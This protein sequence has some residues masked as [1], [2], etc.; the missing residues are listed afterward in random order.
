[1]ERIKWFLEARFGLFIHWGLYSILG[2]GEWVMFHEHIPVEEYRKLMEKF[3]AENYD[4][5]EWARIAK[6]AGMK[7]AVMTSRHHDG[8]SLFDTSVSDFNSLNTPAGRDL[9][10]EYVEAFRSEGL[11]VGIYYSL[12]DWRWPAYWKGPRKDPEGWSKFLNYV[13]TQVEEL[14]SNYGRIDILWYDGG[15]PY[16]AEDWKSRELNER[17]RE[18]QPYIIV[19]NRSGVPGDFETP[20]QYVPWSPPKRPWETCMTMNDSWGYY[21]AD[22]N[23]KSVRQLIRTLVTIVSKGGNLLLNV[24]PKPDGTFPQESIIRLREIGE[25]LRNNGESIYGAGPAPIGGGSVGPTTAKGNIVYLH[26]FRWPGEKIVIGGVKG[27]PLNA[28]ILST[29]E[30]VKVEVENTRLVLSKLPKHPPDKR[31]TVIKIEFE[32][33]PQRIEYP[34]GSKLL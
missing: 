32:E 13:H 29:K 33:K 34:Y 24:G 23:W 5:R 26:V 22:D 8:F 2:R 9:I 14:C 28:Q 7:Y 1:M 15:W 17:V 20:E 27:K 16:S 4:P 11:R 25:W 3:T 31:D 18:L 6:E 12:L 10:K 19:N 30:E 21:E